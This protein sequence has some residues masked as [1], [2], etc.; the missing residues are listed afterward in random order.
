MFAEQSKFGALLVDRMDDED[1][2]ED[3]AQDQVVAE[4]VE[5]AVKRW[6]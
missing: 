6:I 5:A 1:E 3:Q 4:H 2:D